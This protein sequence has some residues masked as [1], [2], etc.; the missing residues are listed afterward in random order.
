MATEMTTTTQTP[1]AAAVPTIWGSDQPAA[2]VT[3]A[4]AVAQ[5]L[6]DVIRRQGLTTSISGR[7]HVRV[8]GWTLLGSMLG[9]FPICAWSRKLEDGW[10]ARV[11]V[12]TAGGHL[13]GAAEAQCTR[14]ERSWA[15]R[16]DFALRSMAQTRATSKAMRLPLGFVMSLAGFDP[17]PAEEM[18]GIAPSGGIPRTPPTMTVEAPVRRGRGRPPKVV[19]AAPAPAAAPNGR[20][21]TDKQRKRLFAISYGAK[22]SNEQIA[23][24]LAEAHGITSTAD[25]TTDIYDEICMWAER[26]SAVPTEEEAMIGDE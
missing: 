23:E 6:A 20:A 9:V 12:R 18:E 5:T 15:T 11:E 8:E 14:Q 4:T 1:S 19:G 13:I 22:K 7:D 10:E 16:D 24:Y 17:T 3:R 26:M 25:I 21:I 2:V